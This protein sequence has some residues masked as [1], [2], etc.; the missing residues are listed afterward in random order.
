M[1]H[2]SLTVG[3]WIPPGTPVPLPVKLQQ[4]T[5]SEEAKKRKLA[6][7]GKERKK[8]KRTAKGD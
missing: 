4:T 3:R 5:K 1:T 2:R 8:E 6:S 7:G